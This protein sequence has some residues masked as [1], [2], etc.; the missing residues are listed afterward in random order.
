MPHVW[1][2]D[3]RVC[4]PLCDQ[5]FKGLVVRWPNGMRVKA[6]VCPTDKIQTFAF[7]P[8]WNKWR[9]TDKTIPCPQCQTPMKWFLR[10]HD[11]YFKAI[12][13]NK[14]CRAIIEKDT[15]PGLNTKGGVE[16]DEFK[17][18]E[19]TERRIEIPIDHLNVSQK[20]KEELRYKVRKQKE[21]ERGQS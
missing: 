21:R 1:I 3:K 6:Y 11:G 8:A 12:C 20:K 15:E 4:C 17:E 5:P 16:L 7:D 9:D 2:P 19:P 18:N 14:V 10:Y 13:P